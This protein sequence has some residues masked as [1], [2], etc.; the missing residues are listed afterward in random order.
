M[1]RIMKLEIDSVYVCVCVCVSLSLSL[2]V[3]V[4]MCLS[5][6]LSLACLVGAMVV[7]VV[8]WTSSPPSIS[9]L[10]AVLFP[11]SLGSKLDGLSTCCF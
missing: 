9:T 8:A 3:C 10:F 7:L 4:S 1:H 5:F 2:C 6:P 11:C